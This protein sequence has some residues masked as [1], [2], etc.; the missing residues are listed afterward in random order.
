M[1]FCEKMFQHFCELCPHSRVS[2]A[3]LK[4]TKV[5]SMIVQGSDVATC[6]RHPELRPAVMLRLSPQLADGE[7]PLCLYDNLWKILLSKSLMF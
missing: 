1:N 6:H 5:S 3:A 2:R 4:L 7:A